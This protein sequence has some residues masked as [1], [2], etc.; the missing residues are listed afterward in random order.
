[1][2]SKNLNKYFKAGVAAAVVVSSGVVAAPI[3]SHAEETQATISF[4][5]LTTK[6]QYY[7]DIMNL[8]QRGIIKGFP[9]NTFGTYKEITRGQAAKILAKVLELDTENVTD[10]GFV[11]VKKIM[12]IMVQLLLYIMLELLMVIQQTTHS[13]WVN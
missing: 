6:N 1:M 2:N 3:V 5:D 4:T 9:D 8:A 7:N 11:D 13:V 10:P 12:N